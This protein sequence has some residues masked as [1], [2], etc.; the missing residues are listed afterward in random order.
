MT[1]MT[2]LLSQVI[3]RSYVKGSMSH[4]ILRMTTSYAY[5]VKVNCFITSNSCS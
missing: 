4:N 3:F 5:D 2:P 1:T